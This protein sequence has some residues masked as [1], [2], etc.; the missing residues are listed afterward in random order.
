MANA[1]IDESN[2]DHSRRPHRV[3][4]L[5]RDPDGTCAEIKH[6]MD[7]EFGVSIGVIINDSFGRPW[8]NG[9]V[10][11]ALGCAGLPAL[12]ILVGQPDLFG[13][14]LQITEVAVAD[15]L[16]AAA[17]ILMG[18]GAEGA[19]V[20]HIRGYTGDAPNKPAEALVRPKSMDMFR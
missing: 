15:E 20:V 14:P 5:P 4:L 17:S 3:L 13:R 1:G 10:G 18:Q 2:I 16:A 6:A 12:A 11:V 19:P 7:S 9:V 8:R